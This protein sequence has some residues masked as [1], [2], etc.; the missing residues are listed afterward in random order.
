V[1][2]RERARARL[3]PRARPAAPAARAPRA[4]P[5]GE[6]EG[7]GGQQEAPDYSAL[8]DAFSGFREDV[9]SRFD[10]L[11]ARVPAPA[12]A[13][14]DDGDAET[15]Y[16]AAQRFTLDDFD[17]EG[18]L[19]PEA[20]QRAVRDLVKAEISRELQPER[21][22]RQR[23]AHTAR[24]NELEEKYPDFKDP[25][26]RGPILQAAKARAARMSQMQGRPELA[27]LWRE[28]AFL[29]LSM[30][31]DVGGR[32]AASQTPAGQQGGVALEHGG[33]A[34]PAGDGG[35]QQDED[36]GRIVNL[37]RQSHFRLGTPG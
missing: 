27:E 17:D 19:K 28:P 21:E 13:A 1:A 4:R 2:P 33:S 34:G 35:N 12:A 23:E 36:A 14:Q 15:D 37:A 24:A 18:N 22:S 10:G 3:A 5:E 8:M 9:T 26:K 29:E 25:A 30:L 20:Q 16:F 6:G 32:A 31:A 7:E 11:E